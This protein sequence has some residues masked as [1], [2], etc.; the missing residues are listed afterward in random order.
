MPDLSF[1]VEK[2]E[3][4]P[5]AAAPLLAFKL[6]VS[7]AAGAMPIQ[8]IALRCQVR[9]EPAKRRYEAREHEGLLD[10]FDTPDR[11]G[12]TLRTML[13]THTSALVGPF[14][15][16]VL[17]DLPVPCS[18]DFNVAATK[19]FHALEGGEVPL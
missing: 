1:N 12:Q 15:D 5:F 14:E 3:V 11:W 19:Y 2:A 6:R 10:L 17:V 18:F 7:Q 4:V 8:A 16:S 13:W 9:I